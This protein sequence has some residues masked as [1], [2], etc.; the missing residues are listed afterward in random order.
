MISARDLSGMP[1]IPSFR[2][3]TRSLAMLDAILSPDWEGRYYSFDSNWGP[4]ELMASMRNGQGDDWFAV[5]VASG[6][7]LIGTAHEAEMY[8]HGDPWPGLFDG[9]PADLAA[10]ARDKAFDPQNT[11][12]C[13]WRRADGRGWERGPVR[14]SSGEDPDGSAELLRHLDRRPESYREFAAEYYEVDVQL[15]DV[16]AIYQHEPLTEQ[17]VRRLN[18]DVSLSDLEADV[19][20]IGYPERG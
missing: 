2:R 8:R 20:E 11:S 16:A 1:D 9:L 7:V 10:L 17:L 12:F 6:V 14:F 18:A 5:I 3:L 19:K 15:T 13:I 4:G